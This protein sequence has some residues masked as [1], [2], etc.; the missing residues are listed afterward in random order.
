MAGPPLEAHGRIMRKLR[1]FVV[2]GSIIAGLLGGAFWALFLQEFGTDEVGLS[3]RSQG[4]SL[5]LED[6]WIEVNLGQMVLRLKVGDRVL[7]SYDVGYGPGYPGSMF[8]REPA[9]PLGEYRI[10]SRHE[11]K[12]VLD[13]G[14]RF[15]VL[16]Y[17]NADDIFDAWQ[18]EVI[19]D[20]QRDRLLAAYESGL[21][22]PSDTPLGSAIGI[23][24]NYFAF[25]SRRFT[26]GSIALANGELNELYR[27][28][29][30]GTRVVIVAQ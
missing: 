20:E 19:D 9:T 5:P 15:L 30:E 3:A 4:L 22:P 23:Q 6:P 8:G 24:G 29:K 1:T 13:R 21:V 25:R 28:V 26:D 14:S 17:P 10:V 16:N 12:Q 18:A 27:H 11:R 2:N 7:G